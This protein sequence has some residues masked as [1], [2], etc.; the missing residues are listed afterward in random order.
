M[1]KQEMRRILNLFEGATGGYAGLLKDAEDEGMEYEY[2]EIDILKPFMVDAVPTKNIWP[3]GTPVTKWFRRNEAE[4]VT[5]PKGK[6]SV[7]FDPVNM[8]VTFNLKNI[9]YRTFSNSLITRITT[10]P[11]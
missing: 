2:H 9:W 6:L 7:V 4:G 5:I 1:G 8:H 10:T 11:E 3:D